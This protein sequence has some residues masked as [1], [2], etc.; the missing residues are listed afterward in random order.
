MSAIYETW[1][2]ENIF[3]DL[4]NFIIRTNFKDKIKVG[5]T[6][7]VVNPSCEFE[8]DSISQVFVPTTYTYVVDVDLVETDLSNYN[9]HKCKKDGAYAYATVIIKEIKEEGY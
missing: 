2:L 3:G 7:K 9:P 8:Y 5:E 6:V 4:S 1:N